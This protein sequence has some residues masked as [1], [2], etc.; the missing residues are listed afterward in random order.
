MD[1]SATAVQDQLA[2]LRQSF[3]VNLPGRVAEIAQAREDAATNQWSEE[4]FKKFH[5]LLHSLAGS[6]ATFGHAEVGQSARQV[7]IIVKPLVEAEIPP[8]PEQLGKID[9]RMEA[10]KRWVRPFDMPR[11]ARRRVIH[12]EA[13]SRKEKDRRQIL[14]VTGDGHLDNRIDQIGFF[15]YYVRHIHGMNGLAKRLAEESPVAVI[16]DTDRLLIEMYSNTISN[17]RNANGE[18]VPFVIMSSRDDLS[19][20]LNAARAGA[21]AYFV[22]PVKVSQ[23]V[24]KLDRMSSGSTIVH[25]RILIIEDDNLL[26]QSYSLALQQAGM[27]THILSDHNL[28]LSQLAEWKPDLIL[29][30]LNMP[31]F[32][33]VELAAVIRQQEEYVSIPIVYLSAE[34]RIEKQL[35][36][37]KLGG[38]DFLTKPIHP[39]HLVASVM[40]RAS[41]SQKLRSLIMRDSLT[42][43]LNHTAIK[44]QLEIELARAK[45]VSTPLAYA[46]LDLDHFKRVN[47]TYGHPTGDGVIKTLARLLLQRLRD[48][49]I[50]GRYGGE[51]FAVILPE[52]SA[53]SAKGILDEIR[54][55]FSK[56][57]QQSGSE[58]FSTTFSAGIAA[59]PEFDDTIRLNDAADRALYQAKQ[60]GRNNVV[61]AHL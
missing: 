54:V 18:R 35:A 58:D 44:G 26:A 31:E 46:M 11:I 36:A 25:Y 56:L 28:L 7:E 14:L 53:V 43:L 17:I 51:E 24:D 41:R 42:G 10:L 27:Q 37:M 47:D 40:A 52:A 45:R 34:T 38:D 22:K 49:D 48:T 3:T 8:S 39:D 20:R 23:M 50:I 30:D 13:V 4:T 12:I 60:K 55:G 19:S 9:E 6:A 61:I 32:T 29:M 57:P 1:N 33:G 21:A 16:I 2:Q 15:G 5:R 59:W